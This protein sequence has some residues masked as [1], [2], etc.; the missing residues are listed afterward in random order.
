MERI[1][2]YGKNKEMKDDEGNEDW[3]TDMKD[4]EKKWMLRKG[5]E[6]LG[7]D[8]KEMKKKERIWRIWRIR[9]EYEELG[10]DMKDIRDKERIWRI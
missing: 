5:Y 6:G 8:M 9:Q 7:K 1:W 2:I 10:K 4:K 3:E